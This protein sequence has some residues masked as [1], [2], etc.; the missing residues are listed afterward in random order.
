MM[1]RR[2]VLRRTQR[3]EM[4]YEPKVRPVPRW[5]A[6]TNPKDRQVGTLE[7]KVIRV[8]SFAQDGFV[9]QNILDP[10]YPFFARL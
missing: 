4:Y 2:R 9:E 8:N 6:K 1:F 5:M 10:V 7:R 3:D